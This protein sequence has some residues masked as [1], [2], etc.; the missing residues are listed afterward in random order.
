ML[1]IPKISKEREKIEEKKREGE[2]ERGRRE[3]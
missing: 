1:S 2:R 3:K